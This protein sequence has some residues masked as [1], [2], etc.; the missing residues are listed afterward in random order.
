M[1]NNK[2]FSLLTVL[3]LAFLFVSC[4]KED[5]IK[6][7]VFNTFELGYNN[8]GSAVIGDELHIDSEIIAEGKISTIRITIHHE[9]NHEK[10]VLVETEWEF[11]STYTTGYAGVKNIDFHEHIDIPLTA[12]AGEYHFHMIVTDMEGN[13]SEKE[14]DLL[15]IVP[16]DNVAPQ[17]SISAA[18]ADMQV[19]VNGE[20]IIIA[21]SVTDETA[22][23]GMYIG[24]LKVSQGLQ[25]AEV[26]ATN[27]IT[28]L[29]NH[30][31]TTDK[32][33]NFTASIKVGATM[34]NNITPKE[35]T[36][37]IAWESGE[38]FLIVKV[39]DAFGGNLGFSKRYRLQ[40]NI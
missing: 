23:G 18:P 14:A 24:L 27:T 29:H 39:K 10:R 35:I 34:D 11:D 30:D 4:N 38:Y 22:L 16:T 12:E 1:K 7:P 21:G 26:N 13:R 25:D 36:G 17:V 31:F 9:G 2:L 8:S 15:L 40:I 3:S 6:A 20:D 19:F 37:E 28:L 33:H 32:Q 5:E